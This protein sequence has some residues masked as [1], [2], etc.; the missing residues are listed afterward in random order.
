MYLYPS[1]HLSFQP[2]MSIS[3]SLVFVK[4]KKPPISAILSS[5]PQI[6]LSIVNI[7]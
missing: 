4:T 6:L 3:L 2:S 1:I 7:F 5:S